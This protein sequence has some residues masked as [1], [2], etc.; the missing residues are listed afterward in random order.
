MTTLEKTWIY[1]LKSKDQTFDKFKEC[2]L[3]V[4]TKTEKELKFFLEQI[5]VLS[6]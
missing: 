3:M 4:E 5:M 6:F 2:K 1:F